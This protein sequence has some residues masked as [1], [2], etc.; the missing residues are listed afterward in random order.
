M[1]KKKVKPPATPAFVPALHKVSYRNGAEFV[2]SLNSQAVSI[3]D[4]PGYRKCLRYWA[5]DHYGPERM[6][7]MTDTELVEELLAEG[8]VPVSVGGCADGGVFLIRKEVLRRA[9][10]LVR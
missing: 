5:I 7:V 9:P 2:E 6:A 1:T 10:W 4:Q 3:G 8:L